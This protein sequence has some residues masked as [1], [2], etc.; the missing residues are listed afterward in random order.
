[1]FNIQLLTGKVYKLVTIILV[2]VAFSCASTGGGDSASSDKVVYS[3]DFENSINGWGS[4]GDETVSLSSDNAQTGDKSLVV[5]NRTSTW[6]GPIKD[7]S[8]ILKPGETYSIGL[9]AKF[10][11]GPDTIGLKLSIQSKDD[12]Y[13]N[14]GGSKLV[15]GEWVYSEVIYSVPSSEYIKLYFETTWKDEGNAEANDLVPFYIDNLVIKR[16]LPIQDP[17]TE[18]G[19]EADIP[20]FHTFYPEFKIGV[21]INSSRYFEKKNKYNELLRHFNGFVYENDMKM[22]AMQPS[23][24]RFIFTKAEKLI[25]YAEDNNSVVRGHTLLWHSQYP[26]WFFTGSDGKDVNKE[27]LL[28]RIKTH[29]QTIAGKFKGRIYAWDVV[30][31]V[32]GDNGELRDSKYLEIIGSDEYISK[33]FIW[34]RE[35]DPDAKLF[36]NDYNIC[37]SGAKQDLLFELVKKL[38]DQG[39]P[40][41]GVGFQAHINISFPSVNEIRKAIRRFAEL[42]VEVQITEL[43]M[44]IYSSSTEGIKDASKEILLAQ[45]YKYNALFE[46]FREE[47]KN[48]SL[49]MVTLWG[50]AD[51]KTWLNNFPTK[52]RTNY[53][54]LFGKDLRAKPAYWATVDPEN[55]S[56]LIKAFDA[57][58]SDNEVFGFDDE[59]WDVVTFKDIMNVKG[60]YFGDLGLLWLKDK[61]YIKVN[62]VDSTMNESDGIKIYIEEHNIKSK[63]LTDNT[64]IIDVPRSKAVEDRNDGYTL[65]YTVSLTEDSGKFNKKI[66]FD[67]RINDN[68]EMHSFNDYSNKQDD[69]TGNYCSVT[70]SKL[71]P[72]TEADNGTIIVDGIID[73]EWNRALVVSLDVETEG[74]TELGSQFRTLWDK[75]F[76]Y[77][78]LE[79]K[80][81]VLNDES[82]NPW[83][84]DSVEIFIDEN[85]AKSVTYENDDAQYRVSFNNLVSFNGGDEVHFKSKTEK[86][87]DGYIVEAAVPMSLVKLEKGLIIGFDIQINDSDDS[88]V[89]SGIRN[90]VNDTNL[91]Y[92]D[93]SSFG[94]MILK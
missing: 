65:F 31:E 23:E 43:D 88:G 1:M 69:S 20:S 76:L 93:T 89:R 56:V 37:Q 70:L 72:M 66:G 62:V 33:A 85:N 53:P 87:K 35:A 50:L 29:I 48:G 11:D 42:G 51:D 36:I 30:N 46:M 78:L 16:F 34:A 32:I 84:Q 55:L 92:Q 15:K 2:L 44:S 81:S 10:D 54:L 21:A 68:G 86:T 74:I 57:I 64:I 14:I 91:G 17:V 94:V 63:K 13:T 45:A 71:A 9:W 75:D 18:A 27:V 8:A 67:L 38:L 47:A 73:K 52:G 28:K 22:D 26:K 60:E 39:V 25:S 3:D 24:G 61:L 90:W 41:D 83:E 40:I 4:R 6:N 12:V 58:K 49:T 77:V 59:A 80:D 82:P 19:A 5:I 7:L 79:I